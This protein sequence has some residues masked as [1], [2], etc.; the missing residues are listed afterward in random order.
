MDSCLT[1]GRSPAT[2][3]VR[4]KDPLDLAH[5]IRVS[6][7]KCGLPVHIDQHRPAADQGQ[8]QRAL[9]SS[10]HIKRHICE[11]AALNVRPNHRNPV[12]IRCRK[13]RCVRVIKADSHVPTAAC[14]TSIQPEQKPC[15]VVGVCDWIESLLE[16]RKRIRMILEVNLH[17][18]DVDEAVTSDLRSYP[19]HCRRFAV[20]KQPCPIGI[21]GPWPWSHVVQ[22][23]DGAPTLCLCDSMQ[24]PMWQ[25]IPLFSLLEGERTKFALLYHPRTCV[26]GDYC[27]HGRRVGVNGGAVDPDQQKSCDSANC[28]AYRPGPACSPM[29]KSCHRT[30]LRRHSRVASK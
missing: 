11:S 13:P 25:V 21:D 7:T 19:R 18:A 20:E 27:L 6:G 22:G 10:A 14:L 30:S 8:S 3:E 1:C 15:G 9:T 2:T 26:G 29:E 28:G 12:A 16:R 17:A 23:C 24:K 4:A 5:G